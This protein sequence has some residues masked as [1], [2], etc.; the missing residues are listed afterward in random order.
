MLFRSCHAGRDNYIVR[1]RGCEPTAAASCAP[2]SALCACQGRPY[3][4]GFGSITI[5]RVLH[6][7]LQAAMRAIICTD[8]SGHLRKLIWLTENKT[9]I[10]A[11]ICEPDTNPHATYH[12]DG[13]YH[14]K[15]RGRTVKMSTPEKRYRSRQSRPSNNSSARPPFMPMTP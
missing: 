2:T 5:E 15:L 12:V 13:T 1:R 8:Y 4:A 3:P 9:G 7:Q 6:I 11:G 14:V 10:S